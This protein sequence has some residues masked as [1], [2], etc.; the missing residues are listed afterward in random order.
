MPEQTLQQKRAAYALEKVQHYARTLNDDAKKKFKT[1]ASELP[2]MI[3]TNGLGQALAFFRSKRDDKD[4]DGYKYLY[5]ILDAWLIQEQRPF[6]GKTDALAG[7]TQ[8]NRATY[9]TAQAEAMMLMDWVKKFASA[10][11]E[12]EAA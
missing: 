10:F 9:L 1:R 2:F 7:V 6:A 4:K 8:C 3:H 11:M 12:G 5:D